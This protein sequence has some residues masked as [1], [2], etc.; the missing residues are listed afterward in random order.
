M[1]Q[2]SWD[3]PGPVDYRGIYMSIRKNAKNNYCI[4][5]IV[6]SIIASLIITSCVPASKKSTVVVYASVD[7]VFS[8]PILKEFQQRTGIEILPVYDVE[9]S[10]TTGLANRLIAEKKKPQADVYWSGEFAQTIMLKEAGIF[11][12][13]KSPQAMDIPSQYVEKDGYWTGFGGRA[14][15]LLVNTSKISPDKYPKSIFDL[16]DERYAEDK[17]GIA[18]PMFGTTATHVATLYAYLGAEKAKDYFK[19]LKA[20][21]VVVVDG[22]SVVR[23]MVASGQLM[24]GLTDTDDALSAKE[25]GK[26][27][28][29]VFLDQDKGGM[30]TLVIPNTVALV[31]NGPNA[32]EGK[33]LIDFLLSKEI[34]E[35]L[36]NSGWIDFTLRPLQNKAVRIDG[37]SLIKMN[38]SL[39][40]AF[41]TIEASQKDMNEIFVR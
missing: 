23:D 20:R 41:K 39:D 15:V 33:K 10:K 5:L 22:N 40:D 9:A 24:M 18:Y 26:P 25:K 7:Q 34:E 29:L 31:A 27:V 21:G 3:D 4:Y 36:Y 37:T 35:R 1:R 19:R 2:Q 13:Y 28:E 12:P 30:G 17:I 6:L 38:T 14:R 11:S 8:E 16:L 32:D